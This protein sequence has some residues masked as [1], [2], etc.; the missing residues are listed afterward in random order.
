MLEKPQLGIAASEANKDRSQYKQCYAGKEETLEMKLAL[1]CA[2]C[3][4]LAIT[5]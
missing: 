2:C 4:L 3:W 1:P 5:V